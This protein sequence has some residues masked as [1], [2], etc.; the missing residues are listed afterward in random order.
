MDI[1][2]RRAPVLNPWLKYSK[3][4]NVY[5]SREVLLSL[6][7]ST[8]VLLVSWDLQMTEVTQTFVEPGHISRP[9]LSVLVVQ[10]KGGN[11]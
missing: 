10:A 4:R 6:L 5:G 8:S 11:V 9:C 1:Q 7:V 3:P 2:C